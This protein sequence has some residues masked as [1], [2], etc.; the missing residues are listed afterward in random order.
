VPSTENPQIERGGETASQKEVSNKTRSSED[1]LLLTSRK[2][3]LA[4]GP[5]VTVSGRLAFNEPVRIEG[6]FRGEISSAHLVVIDSKASVEGRISAPRLI[7]LGELRGDVSG[8]QAVILG[9]LARVSGRI[10]AASL[11]VCE[12]A[13]INGELEIL[14]ECL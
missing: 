1:A 11:K 2:T 5:D 3:R 10:S 14:P 9:P 8:A 13:W 6:C 4:V 12:G 7:V